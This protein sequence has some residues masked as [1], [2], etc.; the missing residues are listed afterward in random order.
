MP[1]GRYRV[2]DRG[3]GAALAEDAEEHGHGYDHPDRVRHPER[4]HRHGLGHGRHEPELGERVED[5]VERHQGRRCARQQHRSEEMPGGSAGA[6]PA[7]QHQQARGSE[8]GQ[9]CDVS[10][11]DER[12]RDRRVG[13]LEA[14]QL[15]RAQHQAD[16][17]LEG[18]RRDEPTM[19]TRSRRRSGQRAANDRAMNARTTSDQPTSVKES[20]SSCMKSSLPLVPENHWRGAPMIT[21]TP[22]ARAAGQPTA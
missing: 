8:H 10:C 5:R 2:R 9:P 20:A 18:E 14:D 21:G 4:R 19:A 7:L 17:G 22:R 11:A 3:T 16:G 12:D 1:D 15:R 13:Q 6:R